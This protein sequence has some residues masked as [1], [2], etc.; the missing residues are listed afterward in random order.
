MRMNDVRNDSDWQDRIKARSNTRQ[1]VWV[2]EMAKEEEEKKW[3]E[4][5]LVFDEIE[6]EMVEKVKWGD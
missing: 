5:F 4:E 3:T 1:S 6:K 2:A